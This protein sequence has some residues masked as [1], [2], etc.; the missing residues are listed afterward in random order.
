MGNPAS[1]QVIV[2]WDAGV[3]PAFYD[4]PRQCRRSAL[5]EDCLEYHG[6]VMHGVVRGV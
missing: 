5:R 3:I 2:F 4:I 6:V 1:E